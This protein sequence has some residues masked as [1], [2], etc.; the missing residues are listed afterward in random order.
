MK[1]YFLLLALLFSGILPAQNKFEADKIVNEGIPYHD[2][3]D[4]EG[5][6]KKYDEALK[7]DSDN[8]LAL[9]EKAFKQKEFAD[10][11]YSE[12]HYLK[13]PNITVPKKMQLGS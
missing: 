3:G 2:K 10:L 13:P 6:I 11:A 12:P 9:A 5:A 7:L 8:L 4:Y 1:N